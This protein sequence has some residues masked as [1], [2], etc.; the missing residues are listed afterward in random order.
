[1]AKMRTRGTTDNTQDQPGLSV[2]K[3]GPR[4]ERGDTMYYFWSYILHFSVC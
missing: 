3:V 1:M 2:D 4:Y